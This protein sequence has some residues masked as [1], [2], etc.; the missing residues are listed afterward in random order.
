MSW[1]IGFALTVAE[2]IVR[3]RY[4]RHSVF[5]V[6]ADIALQAGWALVGKDVRRRDGV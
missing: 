6:D 2:R 5:L 3:K 1:G 4:P